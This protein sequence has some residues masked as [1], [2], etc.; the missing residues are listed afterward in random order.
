MK[1][2]AEYVFGGLTI[3]A[4]FVL[5]VPTFSST[6][7]FDHIAH[8]YAT[9]ALVAKGLGGRWLGA[10][11]NYVT[12]SFSGLSVAAFR[13]QNF[14][15]HLSAAM[16][17]FL[18]FQM[19]FEAL[20]EESWL[21]RFR[22]KIVA[23]AT[24]FFLFHPV[25]AQTALNVDQMRLEGLMVFAV[26]AVL[27]CLMRAMRDASEGA[28]L[29]KN[30][31]FYVAL[32]FGI[33][34]VGT[35]EAVIVLPV[36][37]VLLDLFFLAQGSLLSLISRVWGHVCFAACFYSAFFVV[38]SHLALIDML[39]GG[40]RVLSAPGCLHTMSYDHALSAFGY[41]QAQIPVL[42]HYLW[43]FFWPFDLYFDY[44]VMVLPRL[45]APVILASGLGLALLLI[46]AVVLWV[47]HR[48][49]MVSFGLA[50]FF[51]ALLPRIAFCAPSQELIGNY[52]T[53]LA[54]VGAMVLLAA[55]AWFVI[56]WLDTRVMRIESKM[57]WSLV[58]LAGCWS[59]FMLLG[60]SKMHADLSLSP[61]V[62]WERETQHTPLHARNFYYLGNA[63]RDQKQDEKAIAAYQHAVVLDNEYA[64]PLIALGEVH[65]AQGDMHHALSLYVKAEGKKYSPDLASRLFL[66]EGKAYLA[67]QD[68]SAAQDALKRSLE[69]KPAVIEAS[70][71]YA[72]LLKKKMHFEEAYNFVDHYL[73]ACWEN[74]DREAVLLKARLA[75]ELGNHRE[76]VQLL[77]GNLTEKDDNALAFVL[78]ASQYAIENYKRSAELFERVYERCPDNLDVA[79]N[80]AQALMKS[81]KFAAAVGYFKQCTDNVKYP[82]AQVHVATCLFKNGNIGSAQQLLADLSHQEL[83][84]PVRVQL[85]HIQEEFSRT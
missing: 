37:G 43:I 2:I 3:L 52:K 78:A 77:D 19:L 68:F 62:F 12:F 56:D 39:T 58:G 70:F 50:W 20:P 27:Y 25:Q 67:L 23:L 57:G 24:A 13:M 48:R 1:R 22:K 4:A 80:C 14:A 66:D 45:V 82:F 8:E 30:G 28:L 32:G 29:Y 44:D 5:Y 11:L 51:V 83:P 71:Y 38:N 26:L 10:L 46:L 21:H 7:F 16:L 17:F 72:Q 69:A 65:Q 81:N 36:L 53:F 35:K 76:V 42:L 79:Y 55:V 54:S 59:V 85:M 63:L 6:L 61:V 31:W 33:C 84:E 34:S 47:Y 74:A 15:F 75:F 40:M 60:A 49:N 18:L 64:D 9:G 41:M 73:H